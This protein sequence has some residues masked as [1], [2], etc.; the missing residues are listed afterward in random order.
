MANEQPKSRTDGWAVMVTGSRLVSEAEKLFDS[1]GCRLIYVD[2]YSGPEALRE[3]ARDEQVD[4]I[5][6]RQGKIDREVINASAQLKVIAKHGS[7]VD[8]IDLAAARDRDVPVL[9]ALSANAQSVAELAISLSLSLLKDIPKLDRAVKGGA[10][11]KTSFVGRDIAGARL[12]LIGFGDIGKRTAGLARAIGMD[13]LAFD[14]AVTADE[15]EGTSVTSDFDRVLSQSDIV[16]L[17]CPLT[18]RTKNLI[19]SR[20]LGLMKDDAFLVNT[21]RG[22]L[23]N[24]DALCEALA[25]GTIAGAALDSFA[26]EPPAPDHRL[27]AFDNL[28]ATAHVGGASRSALRNM[29]VQSAS[30]IIEF[31][32]TGSF[33]VAALAN[34]AGS[35]N[36]VNA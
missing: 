4:A 5:L 20:E 16:S 24:E 31:I 34:P 14:P 23:I 30:N 35:L 25:T 7:G 28:I 9:R 2:G 27:F 36:V 29:A 21:A 32:Q 15:F 12:G 18:E 19:A 6:V 22:G 17:H 3:A 11:P 13:T 10:W 26:Q 8:N 1:N 33:D